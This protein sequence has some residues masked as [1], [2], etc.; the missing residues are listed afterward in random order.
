MPPRGI[1]TLENHGIGVERKNSGDAEQRDC[2]KDGNHSA[3]KQVGRLPPRDVR[4]GVR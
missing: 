2:R 4:Q 1:G 3:V